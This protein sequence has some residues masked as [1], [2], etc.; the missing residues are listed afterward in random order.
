MENTAGAEG[1][2]TEEAPVP[3]ELFQEPPRVSEGATGTL[4]ATGQEDIMA[5]AS[6]TSTFALTPAAV[7]RD[8]PLDFTQK[9][10]VAIYNTATQSLYQDTKDRHDLAPAMVQNFLDRVHDRALETSM[11]VTEIPATLEQVGRNNPRTKNIC[12]K[13]GELGYELLEKQVDTYILEETRKRQE[14]HMLLE[15]LKK[16]ITEKAYQTVTADRAKY[17]RKGHESGILFLKTILEHSRVD[18]SIDPDIIRTELSHASAKFKALNYNVIELNTW[19]LQKMDQLTQK[20]E[21]STDTRSNLFN[22]YESSNDE[23]FRQYVSR[24]RDEVSDNPTKKYDYKWLMNRA[25]DKYDRIQTHIKMRSI[26]G[27]NEPREDPI[28]ALTARVDEIQRQSQQRPN[29]NERG[30]SRSNN[31]NRGRQRRTW[32]NMPRE[33][34]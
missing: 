23:E 22:A 15:F 11:T 2:T 14:D 29:N 32:R 10:H 26:T 27:E 33:L 20:G 8:A 19:V 24:L 25:K 5:A 30:E 34:S 3:Q 4:S 28:V 17:I 7:V 6:T 31:N 21:T 12:R 13:H 1:A 16:S 18:S 9:A